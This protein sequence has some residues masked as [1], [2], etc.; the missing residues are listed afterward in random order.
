MDRN[1]LPPPVP[2][3]LRVRCRLREH[4]GLWRFVAAAVIVTAAVA[5]VAYIYG[6]DPMTTADYPQCPSKRFT[7]YDCPG[8]G[9]TRALY[10]LVHGRFADAWRYNALLFVLAPVL[11]L[12]LA[13]ALL[14]PG[15]RLQRITASRPFTVAL[16]AV[17][18]L[19]TL[20]RN[21]WWPL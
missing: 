3:R 13:A 4:R 12:L 10:A 20:A 15:N 2:R 1:P 7:G 5:L 19:W 9:S 6:H 14:P 11:G 21:I 18:V 16:V 17:M 8:C